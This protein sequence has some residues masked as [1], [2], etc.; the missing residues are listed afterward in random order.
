MFFNF[1][2]GRSIYDL[3]VLSQLILLARIDSILTIST[4]SVFHR[5]FN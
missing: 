1:P 5:G 2:I 3:K 4:E